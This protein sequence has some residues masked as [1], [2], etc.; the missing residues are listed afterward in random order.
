MN[1]I[2]P[3]FTLNS[4]PAIGGIGSYVNGL[5]DEAKQI[6]H[7]KTDTHSTL[8]GEYEKVLKEDAVEAAQAKTAKSS[9]EEP[10]ATVTEASREVAGD[11]EDSDPRM[12]TVPEFKPEVHVEGTIPEELKGEMEGMGVEDTV[13]IGSAFQEAL[14]DLDPAEAKLATE[15]KK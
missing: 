12:R 3:T 4:I 5:L 8:I 1:L 15:D 2:N 13:M 7:L 11:V 14:G 9:S 10:T 6:T